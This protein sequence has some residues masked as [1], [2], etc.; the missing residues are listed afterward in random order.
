VNSV[1]SRRTLREA[2][3]TS[4][5][6]ATQGAKVET[7]FDPLD[8]LLGGGLDMGE[9]VVVGGKPG[10]GKT[11][12][13][14]QVAVGAARRGTRVLMVSY[15]HTPDSMAMRMIIAELSS[16]GSERTTTAR[17]RCRNAVKSHFE[18][19][20][21]EIPVEVRHAIASLNVL[22]DNLVLR[23][24][25][26]GDDIDK[27][28][29]WVDT[30]LRPGDLLIVDYLQ[31]VACE[32]E[33]REGTHRAAIVAEALKEIAMTSGICVVAVSAVATEAMNQRRIGMGDLLGGGD[34]AHEADVILTLNDKS[35]AVAEA[36]RL[37]AGQRTAEFAMSTVLSVEKHRDGPA[38]AHMEFE[39]D[40]ANFAF[41]PEGA[42]VTDRLEA[43]V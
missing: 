41:V 2:I 5:R 18:G 39:K 33:H 38:P 26:I 9:L 10:V 19:H 34:L 4:G 30:D 17:I 8:S 32:H 43:I 31:K 7:G 37:F 27:V 12:F 24:G 22:G 35:T 40:F 13:V 42:F 20:P 28:V 11:V 29:E 21:V 14:S 15:E 6:S 36:H 1:G 23:R 3:E 16:V 25:S